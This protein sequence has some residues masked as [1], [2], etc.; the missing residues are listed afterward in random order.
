MDDDIPALAHRCAHLQ[1]TVA[2]LQEELRRQQELNKAYHVKLQNRDD[3]IQDLR[4]ALHKGFEG[5]IPPLKCLDEMER[6]AQQNIVTFNEKLQQQTKESE[7][8]RARLVAH[9]TAI[10]NAKDKQ[11][12]QKSLEYSNA[13]SMLSGDHVTQVEALVR[14]NIQLKEAA[15]TLRQDIVNEMETETGMRIQQA[16]AEVRELFS[17]EIDSLTRE[18]SKRGGQIASL[19]TKYSEMEREFVGQ[20]K[21]LRESLQ[22]K[23]Q[24]LKHQIIEYRCHLEDVMQAVEKEKDDLQKQVVSLGEENSQLLESIEKSKHFAET[25]IDEMQSLQQEHQRFQQEREEL[26]QAIQKL[27]STNAQQ[28]LVLDSIQTQYDRL[29]LDKTSVD[30]NYKKMKLTAAQQAQQIAVLQKSVQHIESERSTTLT[31]ARSIAPETPSNAS[32]QILNHSTTTEVVATNNTLEIPQ[33][34]DVIS[35]VW[36][37]AERAQ[38]ETKLETVQSRAVELEVANV[39]LVNELDVEKGNT[40]KLNQVISDLKSQLVTLRTSSEK[41]SM[42]M[43]HQAAKD[44]E[45]L[46]KEI[47]SKHHSKLAELEA[48]ALEQATAFNPKTTHMTQGSQTR[49][50]VMVDRFTYPMTPEQRPLRKSRSSRYLNMMGGGGS[51]DGTHTPPPLD[52]ERLSSPQKAHKETITLHSGPLMCTLCEKKRLLGNNS[53]VH[54]RNNTTVRSSSAPVT[55]RRDTKRTIQLRPSGSTTFQDGMGFDDKL[56]SLMSSEEM[57]AFQKKW[58]Q[59]KAEVEAQNSVFD[60]LHQRAVLADAK[61]KY[62]SESLRTSREKQW[63]G[64]DPHVVLADELVAAVLQG[65]EAIRQSEIVAAAQETQETSKPR[66]G[67]PATADDDY[68]PLDGLPSVSVSPRTLSSGKSTGL[69]ISRAE[70]LGHHS[71]VVGSEIQMK[72]MVSLT[73][74]P[75]T[76]TPPTSSRRRNHGGALNGK[77]QTPRPGTTV[78][79]HDTNSCGPSPSPSLYHHLGGMNLDA[80]ITGK[81]YH[82]VRPPAVK[83]IDVNPSPS[84]PAPS[85]LGSYIRIDTPALECPM[86]EANVVVTAM[87]QP[88]PQPPTKKLTPF[89]KQMQ[90]RSRGMS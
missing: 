67:S 87:I 30:E 59:M 27:S 29:L 62:E 12:M 43:K 65:S 73:P 6:Q 53:G 52:L 35:D 81:S 28:Q 72:R 31:S 40:V 44:R 68:V 69:R 83:E 39:R 16:V 88:P 14:E 51:D 23:D 77:P 7:T 49:V 70:S 17:S 32:S 4:N 74:R 45:R 86:T 56:S 41:A 1:Q 5:A 90:Q 80:M 79:P 60:R 18:V 48:H 26:Q 15:Q 20:R 85:V 3:V 63:M 34:H 36:E 22:W 38:M 64:R 37:D 50:V 82:N 9:Y 71:D 10:I 13:I 33:S 47:A 42:N 84:V 66:D 54:A 57:S 11:Y 21:E 55:S 89:Q 8:V 58:R 78:P 24:L 25:S 2:T 19:E 46:E 76:S 61:Q 75:K